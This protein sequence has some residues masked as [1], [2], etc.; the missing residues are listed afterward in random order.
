MLILYRSEQNQ[1]Q[2][3]EK[4]LDVSIVSK[5]IIDGILQNSSYFIDKQRNWVHKLSA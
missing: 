4:T 3:Y 5:Y 2:C 1:G